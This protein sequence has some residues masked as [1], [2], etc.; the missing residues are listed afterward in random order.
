M[1]W[2]ANILRRTFSWWLEVRSHFPRKRSLW[3]LASTDIW[4]LGISSLLLGL[5]RL[6]Q[7]SYRGRQ[8]QEMSHMCWL[9]L[10]GCFFHSLS[11]TERYFRN[12]KIISWGGYGDE[13]K[14]F[15]LGKLWDKFSKCRLAWPWTISVAQVGQEHTVPKADLVH[16]MRPRWNLN[17]LCSPGQLWIHSEA[18]GILELSCWPRGAHEFLCSP[19]SPSIHSAAQ[20][21][22]E[23]AVSHWQNVSS[24]CGTGY[25]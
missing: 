1:I 16:T 20:T 22:L 5:K 7:V 19:H 8:C 15:M 2:R 18:L 12:R 10:G 6:V 21:V 3:L 9:L 25:T 14:W 24:V 13:T 4:A 17:S 23:L 11:E